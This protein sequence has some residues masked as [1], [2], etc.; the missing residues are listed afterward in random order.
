[1]INIVEWTQNDRNPEVIA[2]KAVLRGG[3]TAS[4]QIDGKVTRYLTRFCSLHMNLKNRS[5]EI[6]LCDFKNLKKISDR[7]T[8]SLSLKTVHASIRNSFGGVE[9]LVGS[10]SIKLADKTECQWLGPKGWQESRHYFEF[11]FAS[12]LD[13]TMEQPGPVQKGYSSRKKVLL[14]TAVALI[15]ASVSVP[16]VSGYLGG[17]GSSETVPAHKIEIMHTPTLTPAVAT[18]VDAHMSGKVAENSI[19]DKAEA[20][21]P[22]KAPVRKVKERLKSRSRNTMVKRDKTAVKETEP[23]SRLDIP[24]TR[25]MI[26]KGISCN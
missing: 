15:F 25:D 10:Y 26:E 17:G 9:P 8:L 2:V 13:L 11:P 20:D 12:G 5:E 1:M 7:H 23:D 18:H 19:A 4:F 16:I 22:E 6:L 24:C 14:A 3:L 21:V